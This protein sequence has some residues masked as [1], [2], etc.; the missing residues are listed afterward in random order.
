L[1]G[2]VAKSYREAA[3]GIAISSAKVGIWSEL[4]ARAWKKGD[5]SERLDSRDFGILVL[6]GCA[7]AERV[8]GD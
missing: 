3:L 1:N 5:V 8:K 2:W 7:E 6:F 4:Y